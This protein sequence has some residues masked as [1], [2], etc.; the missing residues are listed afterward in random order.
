MSAPQ[1]KS[2]VENQGVDCYKPHYKL[3]LENKAL[4]RAEYY[5]LLLEK[6]KEQAGVKLRADKKLVQ[7]RMDYE[8]LAKLNRPKTSPKNNATHTTGMPA[9]PA[10]C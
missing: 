5:A 2:I 8:T 6:A 1:S 4:L 9:R 10:G 7:D 3:T